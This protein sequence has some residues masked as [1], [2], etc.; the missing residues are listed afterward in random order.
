MPNKG[1]QNF[2]YSHINRMVKSRRIKWAGLIACM[3]DVIGTPEF[4]RSFRIKG[5]Y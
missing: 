1:L 5:Y 3:G 2:N 4:K